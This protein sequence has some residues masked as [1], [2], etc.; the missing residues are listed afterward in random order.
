MA[1]L[2]AI[3]RYPVKSLPG[4]TLA[5]TDLAAGEGIAFDRRFAIALDAEASADGAWHPCRS[6]LINAQYDGLQKFDIGGRPANDAVEIDAPTG[7][8]LAFRANDSDS[9]AAANRELADFLGKWLPEAATAPALTE[10]RQQKGERSGYWDYSDSAI[11]IINRETVAA[12]G[13][14]IG[15]SLDPRRFRGNLLIDGAQ[16]FEEFAWCGRKLR[17]GAAE[18]EILR[19]IQRCPATSVDPESGDRDLTLPIS[20]RE[21]FGHAFCGIYAKVVKGGRITPDT[22]ITVGG[23]AGI[24]LEE[25]SAEGPAYPL[26]PKWMTLAAVDIGD[27]ATE[28]RLAADQLWPLPEAAAGQR[29]RLHI[30]AGKWTSA[31]IKAAEDRTYTVAI[32]ESAT[33][34]PATHHLRRR[35]K[36]GDRVLTSGPFGRRR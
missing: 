36:P 29:L 30:G 33:D 22:A 1:R 5:E 19:P 15:K 34:D 24:T 10:R 35:M 11:S 25:G 21:R 6:F 3:Y 27:H 32:I 17:I 16:P 23:G 13:K 14:T 2:A 20:L 4:E 12:I 8:R 7:A 9:L 28:L 31:G 26:W 18:L